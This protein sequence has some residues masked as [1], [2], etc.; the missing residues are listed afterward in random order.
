MHEG[1]VEDYVG[2]VVHRRGSPLS[3]RF[4]GHVLRRTRRAGCLVADSG[5]VRNIR[6]VGAKSQQK[7]LAIPDGC[8][9]DSESAQEGS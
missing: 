3:V 5:E 2:V 1:F 4:V 6:S 7:V 8:D 9:R